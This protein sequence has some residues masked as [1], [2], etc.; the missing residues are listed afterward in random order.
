MLESTI[1]VY[2]YEKNLSFFLNLRFSNGN[3]RKRK[4][5]TMNCKITLIVGEDEADV[6]LGAAEAGRKGVRAVDLL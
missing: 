5:S 6:R 1:K 2:D 4:A 3:N